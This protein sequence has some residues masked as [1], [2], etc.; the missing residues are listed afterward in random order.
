MNNKQFYREFAK[1]RDLPIFF[2]PWW[3]DSVA[4]DNWDVAIY[5]NENKVFGIF[6][7]MT[8]K[9][10]YGN[11][12]TNPQF[13]TRLGPIIFYEKQ[14]SSNRKISYDKK[15]LDNLIEQL[16]KFLLFEMGFYYNIENWLPFYWK[17]FMQTTKYSYQLDLKNSFYEG[18]V[19][20]KKSDIKKAKKVV[21][22]KED[23]DPELFYKLHKENLNK[24]GKDIFFTKDFFLSMFNESSER[25]QGKIFYATDGE[26][27]HSAYFIVWDKERS[28]FMINMINQ[29]FRNS[30]STTLLMSEVFNFLKGRTKFCDMAGSMIEGV[31]QSLRNYGSEQISYYAIY[32]YNGLAKL[33]LLKG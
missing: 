29:E 26:N 8:T 10:L 1:K 21:E 30:G 18:L 24:R 15:V 22:I 3:L 31:E 16:P 6:P 19:S 12:I 5:K 11:I 17:G 32:K 2:T 25:E 13:T 23:L 9:K 33:K 4:K 14:Q 20:S 27:I 28:Y 7:Y